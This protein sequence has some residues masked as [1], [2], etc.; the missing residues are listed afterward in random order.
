MNMV[1]VESFCVAIVAL[2][3]G[4]RIAFKGAFWD[5][6]RLYGAIAA[7]AWLTENTCIHFYGFYSYSPSWHL[8]IDQVPIMIPM[9]WPIVVLSAR[10]LVVPVTKQHPVWTAVF[11]G[12][13]VFSDAAFIEPISV[14]LG[15][16][17]WYEPGF[18]DVPVIG[19]I[20][21]GLFAMF[22]LIVL[23]PEQNPKGRALLLFPILAPALTHL[24]L[25]GLWWGCFRWIT[26]AITDQ[27]T[28]AVSLVVLGALS[29]MVIASKS[30]RQIGNRDVW[31]RFPAALFFFAL[32]AWDVAAVKSELLI[33]A[34]SFS[35]P[36][37][38]LCGV[39][40]RGKGLPPR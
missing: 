20:G 25:L 34:V 6:L 9:I 2:S 7:V 14:H 27:G 17:Q 12:L 11:V 18:F 3:L 13:L 21:W 23:G 15:F 22:A 31:L 39:V 26:G 37:L 10:D 33:F 32:L 36:Y 30:T 29:V 38:S 19:V 16:W 8:F 40:F 24:A 5:Q 1:V 4:L 35:M 28:V